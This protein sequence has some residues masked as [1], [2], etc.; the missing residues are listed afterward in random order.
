MPD[1]TD[2]VSQQR[3]VG[4]SVFGSELALLPDFNPLERLFVRI[5]GS[6]SPT[7]VR[8]YLVFKHLALR[9]FKRE[10]IKHKKIL[11]FGCAFGA[12]GFLLARQSNDLIVC[13]H[14]VDP[15]AEKKCKLIIHNGKFKNVKYLSQDDLKNESDFSLTLLGD[16]LEHIDDDRAA[17][18][19]IYRRTMPGG[20]LYMTVPTAREL[21]DRAGSHFGHVR[22]GYEFEQIQALLTEMGFRIIFSPNVRST[23]AA[24][25][26]SFLDKIY[27]QLTNFRDGTRLSF[28]TLPNVSFGKKVALAVIWPLYRV[29]M[30]MD[31]IAH[32]IQAGSI[33]VLAQK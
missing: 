23:N 33:V 7:T 14:D 16:V 9:Y 5:Y 12:F 18:E 32:R 15:E 20:Y 29:A 25:Y 11:D 31:I 17:V 6:L 2:I 21:S 10:G 8:R 22:G 3:A 30:E 26:L 28:G 1:A 27:R 19:E 24:L 4:I 13:L